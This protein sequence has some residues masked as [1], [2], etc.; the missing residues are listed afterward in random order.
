MKPT[1]KRWTRRFL[2]TFA[3]VLS[4]LA[5][6]GFTYEQLGR[7]RDRSHPFRIGQGVDIGGRAINIDCAGTGSPTVIF[8]AGGGG[9]GGYGWKTV[10]SG[11]AKFAK[12]C[13]YDRAGEG[14]SDSAPSA[15]NSSMVAN[16]LHEVLQRMQIQGPFV[17]VGHSI[18][19]E[20]IRIY[21][22]KFP[23]DVVGLVLVD[24]THPDQREP[25][26]MLSPVN[27]MP[28]PARRA[29]C[30]LLP[31]AIRFG[32]IRFMLRNTSLETP[33]E[34]RDHPVEAIRT[35]R[36]QLVNGFETETVQGCTATKG[37]AIQP[38][39]GSGD[40]EVDEAAR[41]SGSV[42]ARPLLVLTA[43][44]YWKPAN[45][46]V[47]AEQISEF[48]QVW[49][50]QLQASLASLSTEGKQLVVENASHAIPE[51]APEAIV[52]AVYQVVE[53]ARAAR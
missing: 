4:F 1:T 41:R 10:Q 49:V 43:G 38:Q 28:I 26:L 46:P 19:G 53:K 3:L 11:V 27:R 36:D 21:T 24:S 51:D 42:G 33:P 12:A 45:D 39:S 22:A 5:I 6:A 44:Q 52:A 40:P 47:S 35:L 2:C 17:L 30:A 37:G 31:I 32:V 25:P 50:K 14:W 48:H 9:R 23:T 18:G 16:D 8:E 34:F 13:W 20:Y 29:M 7:S 15:R